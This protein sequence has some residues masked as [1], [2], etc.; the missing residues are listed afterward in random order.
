ME[1]SNKH[2]PLLLIFLLHVLHLFIGSSSTLRVQALTKQT[3]GNRNNT[4]SAV[5]VFG[6]S[7]VDPGNNNYVKTMFRSNFQ[8]Y[9]R[10]FPNQKPTGRFT[11]GRLCTDYFGTYILI[12]HVATAILCSS[13]RSTCCIC[14]LRRTIMICLIWWDVIINKSCGNWYALRSFIRG[15]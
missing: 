5:L 4:I 15:C 8:P 3:D 13:A 6:D 10:D 7:T 12:N 14:L 11:N 1:F 9:G 2:L